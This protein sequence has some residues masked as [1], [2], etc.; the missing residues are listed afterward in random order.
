[1]ALSE[2]TIIFIFT[3][4]RTI[5]LVIPLGVY[6]VIVNSLHNHLDHYIDRAATDSAITPYQ[7]DLLLYRSKWLWT[8]SDALGYGE[9]HGHLMFPCEHK[10]KSEATTPSYAKCLGYRSDTIGMTTKEMLKIFLGLF[11]L[12]AGHAGIVLASPFQWWWNKRKVAQAE[13]EQQ[14]NNEIDD[15]LNKLV[16]HR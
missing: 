13:E 10:F 1:M 8:Y 14:F 5:C 7:Q 16:G 3:V 11:L 4:T 6:L 15:D 9:L 12:G 2:R